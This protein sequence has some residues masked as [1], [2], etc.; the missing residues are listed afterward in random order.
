MTIN[1]AETW[2]DTSQGTYPNLPDSN[3]W[4]YFSHRRLRITDAGNVLIGSPFTGTSK[5]TVNGSVTTT[6][7]DISFNATGT[8]N[9][10]IG[11]T[12]GSLTLLGNP[13]NINVNNGADITNIGTGTTSG[14]VNIGT[15]TG[16]VSLGNTTGSLTVN[17]NVGSIT[18]ASTLDLITGGAF[19]LNTSTGRTVNIN[20]GSGA[21]TTT[22]GNAAGTVAL[23]GTI[24]ITGTTVLAGNTTIANTAG[25]TLIIGNSTGAVTFA[26]STFGLTTSGQVDINSTTG[27]TTNINTGTGAVTTTD[28]VIIQHLM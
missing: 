11:N 2:T 4:G 9:T 14:A 20:T 17:G 3:N 5:L 28:L 13:V 26:A 21:V 18:T 24:N 12:T 22:I 23:N 1:A 25:N 15:G 10:S 16:N 7:G 27:R 8:N 6:G 19:G